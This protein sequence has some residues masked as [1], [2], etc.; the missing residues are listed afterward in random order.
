M[1]L[2]SSASIEGETTSHYISDS[3]KN[4]KVKI[5]RLAKGVPVGGEIESLDD[6]WHKKYDE[7]DEGRALRKETADQLLVDLEIDGLNPKEHIELPNPSY[8]P[9]ILASG[10]PFLGY[11]IIYKSLA[12]AGVGLVLLLIGGFG[13][14]LEPLEEEEVGDS[15]DE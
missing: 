14:A 12:L 11:A 3:L 9:F 13:W 10:L 5:T 4:T 8:F 15:L 7:D 2:A 6:F 1:I